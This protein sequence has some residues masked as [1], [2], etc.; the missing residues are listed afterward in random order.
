MASRRYLAAA[1]VA[2]LVAAVAAST[3]AATTEP[4]LNGVV[5]PGFTI[6]LKTATGKTVKKLKPGTYVFKISDKASIHDFHLTGPGV[7]KT[8]SVSGTGS[9]TWTLTLKKGNYHYQCDP[10]AS[11]LNGNFTVG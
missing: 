4:V 1:C 8:T 11:T 9:F 2:A 3:A 6:S 7:N 10:H 5:G